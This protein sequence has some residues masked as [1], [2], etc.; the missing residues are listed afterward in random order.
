MVV[1]LEQYSESRRL[2]ILAGVSTAIYV[3]NRILLIPIFP[4]SG[5]LNNYL[6]DILAL[7]VYLPLSVYLS[8]KLEIIPHDFQLN[9]LHVLGAVLLFSIIFEG[10]VPMI[11]KS[12]TRDPLDVLAYLSGGVLVFVV[13]IDGK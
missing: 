3:F 7:P 9:H 8:L 13:K 4:D 12:A 11:D 1:K 2:M 5:F 6:G 10:I